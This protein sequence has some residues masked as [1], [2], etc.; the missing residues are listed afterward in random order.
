MLARTETLL[1]TGK[2][3]KLK[4]G[5]HAKRNYCFVCL[6]LRKYAPTRKEQEKTQNVVKKR[7]KNGHQ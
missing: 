3:K 1:R 4:L 7:G 5:R 6:L 2:R